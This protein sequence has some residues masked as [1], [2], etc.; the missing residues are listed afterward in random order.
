MAKTAHNY[1]SASRSAKSGHRCEPSA[2]SLY[3]FLQ[4][5]YT[6]SYIQI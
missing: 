1:L 3:V 6:L 2:P 5:Q 4:I